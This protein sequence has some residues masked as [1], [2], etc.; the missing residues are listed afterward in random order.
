MALKLF[1]GRNDTEVARVLQLFAPTNPRR[2]SPDL[3]K[4]RLCAIAK[5]VLGKECWAISHIQPHALFEHLRQD[6]P[7][8]DIK[9]TIMTVYGCAMNV[10]GV[11]QYDSDC[12][13]KYNQD[14]EQAFLQMVAYQAIH[15]SSKVNT[16]AVQTD[17]PAEEDLVAS[18]K[19][20]AITQQMAAVQLSE[21][22]RTRLE[23]IAAKVRDFIQTKWG[24]H[25]VRIGITMAQ[26]GL[27]IPIEEE[28]DDKKV[29]QSIQ[30]A[31]SAL[32]EALREESEP[33]PGQVEIQKLEG[34]IAE[35]QANLKELKSKKDRLDALSSK[36]S[37][38]SRCLISLKEQL[39]QVTE[40]QA[41]H[42][43]EIRE[44]IRAMAQNEGL[45]EY[46]ET[47]KK[48]VEQ[49][50]AE[51]PKNT[52]L[53]GELDKVFGDFQLRMFKEII[54]NWSEKI[55]GQKSQILRCKENIQRISNA[56]PAAPTPEMQ[57][58]IDL[59]QQVCAGRS[60]SKSTPEGD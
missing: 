22:E 36:L 51:F 7:S 12:V 40:E 4:E 10:L 15:H 18:M 53:A 24:E 48:Q 14:L 26:R 16:V 5:L 6:Y 25:P 42:V 46:P 9:V 19:A 60:T 21:A 1:L 58:L 38:F 35:L 23:G 30:N 13:L 43:R 8:G 34:L 55:Q 28:W 50:L 17:A 54:P 49:A 59:M 3:V 33:S 44:S 57:E 45:E 29:K 52:E 56:S 39:R 2:F 41:A 47:K 32:L 11:V 27:A 20:L 31:I 37:E